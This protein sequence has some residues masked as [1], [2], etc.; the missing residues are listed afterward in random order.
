MILF[1][2][3]LEIVTGVTFRVEHE[4][5]GFRETTGRILFEDIYSDIE[6]P[7]FDKSAVDGF[8][9][10]RSDLFNELEVI[11]IIPAGKAPEKEIMKDQ[12]AKIMTGAPLPIGSD[13]VIMVEDVE[14]LGQNRIRYKREKVKNNICFKGEDIKK[15][16]VVLKAGT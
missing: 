14:E 1:E 16:E 9:C 5:I 4:R 3:A 12:C 6:M 2:Q 10:R 13:A 8:A 15:G 11:E 7:P